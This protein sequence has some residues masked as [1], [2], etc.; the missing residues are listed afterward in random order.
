MKDEDINKILQKMKIPEPDES[1]KKATIKAV[2]DEYHQQKLSYQN[3]TLYFPRL[4]NCKSFA[5]ATGFLAFR[6]VRPT[7]K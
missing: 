6:I 3:H 5:T 1:T 2:M 4:C 7:I